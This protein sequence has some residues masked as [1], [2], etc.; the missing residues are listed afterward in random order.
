MQLIFA[1][2]W[3]VVHTSEMNF[4]K[5]DIFSENIFFRNICQLMSL[6]H[7]SEIIN[8]Y[9]V[10][11]LFKSVFKWGRSRWY[12]RFLFCRFD[13]SDKNTKT[14]KKM[15]TRTEWNKQC[16]PLSCN[17]DLHQRCFFVNFPNIFGT[18]FLRN[19]YG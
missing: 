16:M 8:K 6:V 17:L 9:I 2:A 13:N 4:W 12:F 19:I 1:Y 10:N 7:I 14:K 3:S 5:S 11:S 15:H 18:G